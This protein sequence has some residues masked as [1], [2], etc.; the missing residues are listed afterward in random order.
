MTVT[1][2]NAGV[3]NYTVTYVYDLNN[4]LTRSTRT[5][6]NGT[7][8][9][10]SY[11]YDR[12]GNQLTQTT[13][14]QTETTAYNGFNQPVTFTQRNGTQHPHLTTIYTY[15]TDGL[16]HSKTMNGNTTTHVWNGS[17][18]VLER[19]ANGAVNHRYERCVTGQ[20]IRSQHHGWYLYNARGDVVQRT[21][22]N[23]SVAHSYRYDAFGNEMNPN[24][25]DTNLFRY[26][27]EYWDLE[28][29]TYYL[30]ARKYNPRTGRFTQPDPY[31][32]INNMIYG[33]NPVTMGHGVMRPDIL[34][35]MQS[36][37][38][39]V[40]ML[41]NPIF[42]IDPNGLFVRKAWGATK[43]FIQ[44]HSTA[45]IT[46]AVITGAAVLT[47]A[48]KGVA[49]PLLV[50]AATSKIGATVIAIG[51]LTVPKVNQIKNKAIQLT[52]QIG[53][54]YRQFSQGNFRHNL[55]QLTGQS[56]A[57]MQAHH[58]FPQAQQFSVYF[59]RAGINVNNPAFGSWVNSSHQ[60][61]SAAYNKAWDAFFSANPG[62]TVQ[63]IFQK[64]TE[65]ANEFGFTIN[66]LP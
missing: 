49:A 64:A 56:G 28:T 15:R 7:T 44:E 35:I 66:F 55:Q 9:M 14:T 54:V 29:N 51:T 43:N 2:A 45:I 47:V 58:V 25:S 33:T 27:G 59:E 38:L 40:S 4:R 17:S 21:N 46:G 19:N 30:R 5:P 11:N 23:G 60:S 36:G 61:W 6:A 32:T 52:H 39:Y 42:W 37:N 24:P 57:G 10:I 63:Q 62:A 31:W 1:G 13:S 34:A 53:T 41:N 18:I 22:S 12:N 50:K 3:L 16:R 65:L 8:E 20:L 26:A 48:T